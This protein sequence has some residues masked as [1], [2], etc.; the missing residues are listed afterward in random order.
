MHLGRE[1]SFLTYKPGSIL[2][3]MSASASLSCQT[4]HTT[5]TLSHPSQMATTTISS[6]KILSP[7]ALNI[8]PYSHPINPLLQKSS[9]NFPKFI[10]IHEEEKI[11]TPLRLEK[12]PPLEKQLEM[13]KLQMKA[14]KKNF[15]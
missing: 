15:Y 5:Q 12:T 13:Q 1:A 6:Q 11:K 8:P 14:L 2:K 9:D 3:V 7:A 10:H 4:C